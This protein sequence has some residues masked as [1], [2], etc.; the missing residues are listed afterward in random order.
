MFSEKIAVLAYISIIAIFFYNSYALYQIEV[1][2]IDLFI[3]RFV[4]ICLVT[5]LFFISQRN[6]QRFVFGQRTRI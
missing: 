1:L 5:L 3:L 2:S 6:L 4:L